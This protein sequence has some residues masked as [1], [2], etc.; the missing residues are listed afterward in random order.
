MT[1]P[2]GM[3]EGRGSRVWPRARPAGIKT[4]VF[5]PFGNLLE[6]VALAYGPIASHHVLDLDSREFLLNVLIVCTESEEHIFL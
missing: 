5:E 2:D 6:N 4:I 1:P 3:P